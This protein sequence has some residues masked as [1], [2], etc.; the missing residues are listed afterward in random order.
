MTIDYTKILQKIVPEKDGEAYTTLRTATVTALNGNN[1]VNITLSG[2]AVTNVP[3]VGSILNLS[4][5]QAAQV[6]TYRGGLLA[7]G[8]SSYPGTSK[9]NALIFFG[10]PS[11]ANNSVQALTPS[12][13]PINDGALW[14]SGTNFLVPSGQ[15]GVYEMGMY[16][17][18]ATQ[19]TAS[20]VRQARFNVNG[21]EHTLFNEPAASNYNNS[22]IVANGVT[23]AFLNAGDVVVFY[24]F[25]NSGGA[26]LLALNSIGWI[27]RVR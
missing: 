23:R 14:S 10:T 12:S 3:I 8:Q 15:S 22:N 19:A 16:L 7:L 9:P 17:R 25:Q 5:G 11:I 1:T 27:E 21:S 20:G 18:Y 4:V 13:V 26:L 2:T 6:L 24:A